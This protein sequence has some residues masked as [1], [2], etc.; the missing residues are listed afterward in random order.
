MVIRF[1]FFLSL[2]AFILIS[3]KNSDSYT[4]LFLNFSLSC[5]ILAITGFVLD[6]MS[7]ERNKQILCAFAAIIVGYCVEN[8]IFNSKKTSNIPAEQ[9]Q[10]GLSPDSDNEI[11][12]Q[13][14]PKYLSQVTE[15]LNRENMVLESAFN[16]SDTDITPLD[17]YFTINVENGTDLSAIMN[18]IKVMDGVIWIEANEN[19][20]FEFPQSIQH[21]EPTA[22]GTL[23]N[24]PSVNLQWHLSFLHMDAY[25][26]HFKEKNIQPVRKAKLYI[27]DTGVDSRHEDLPYPISQS[28]DKQ[29]HGTHC[30]G[31]AAAITNNSI[32]VAS[33]VPDKNWVEIKG[34]QVIGDIGF[35]TQKTIIDGIIKAVDEG[36]D[37]ISMSLG[38]ITNQEREKAYNDAVRYANAKGCIVVVAAGN[39]NLDGKRYSPANTQNVITVASVNEKNEKS[40]FSNSVQNL[41][42]GISAPG[43]K[44]LSTTPSNSYTAFSGTSMATPQVAGLIAVMKALK[45]SL[46]TQ[47]IYN[48][49]QST[50]HETN[51][52]ART[53]KL[54]N[55]FGAIQ[56]VR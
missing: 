38:G 17:E 11:L 55:P 39:A 32:G 26:Y 3:Y 40:G 31:V 23:S 46:T 22:S 8:S 34:I 28:I 5:L 7:P 27:L 1:L 42:M 37:V 15:F 10:N 41:T 54:I 9:T 36:A 2:M 21:V 25:Y 44:I 51:N 56:A 53:G 43:E 52:T 24:D 13:I 35:G 47:E 29:G 48:I 49:L 16:P 45:P 14:D 12:L 18:K 50:G 33:M 20:P 19:I 6:L 4:Q 30:A